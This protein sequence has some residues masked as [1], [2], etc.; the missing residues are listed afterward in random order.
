IVQHPV[1]DSTTAGSNGAV[2]QRSCEFLNGLNVL[3][4]RLSLI[5]QAIIQRLVEQ[6]RQ[7]A[8]SISHPLCVDNYLIVHDDEL[9]HLRSVLP[10][11]ASHTKVRRQDSPIQR[12]YLID[13]L[14]IDVSIALSDSC[15]SHPVSRSNGTEIQQSF[16]V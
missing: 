13:I 14:V 10:R 7:F 8:V 4:K 5:S 6:N 12:S 11:N 16:R 1:R 9:P 2:C 15:P 3:R